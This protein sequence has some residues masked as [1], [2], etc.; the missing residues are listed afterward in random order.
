MFSAYYFLQVIFC[1]AILYGYYL[2]VLRNKPFHQYNRFYLL[3]VLVL[4][5]LIPLMRIEVA[6][7]AQATYREMPIKLFDV[8]TDNN[9]HWEEYVSNEATPFDWSAMPAYL[10]AGVCLLLVVMLLVSLVRI[11]QLLKKHSWKNIGDATLVMTS[12]KEAPFSFFRFIF[13]N[14]EIDIN[15]RV[16]K[17]IL[18]HELAHVRERHSLD[19]II[20]SLILSIGWIN[21][22]FWLIRRELSMVHE[23]I[24]D[25]QAVED[26][27]S[28]LAEMLLAASY[29]T[30][31]FGI[32]NSF[33][34]SPVKRRLSML[35]AMNITRFAYARRWLILPLLLITII[36]FAFRKEALTVKVADRINNATPGQ[37]PVKPAFPKMERTVAPLFGQE[38]T[39]P[40]DLERVYTVVIDPGHGGIDKGAIAADG[41][42]EAS[43][44]LEISKQIQELNTNKNLD[45]VL[46]REDDTYMHPKDKAEFTQKRKADLF[47][48]VHVNTAMENESGAKNGIEIFLPGSDSVKAYK[49]SYMFA[50]AIGTFLQQVNPAITLKTRKSGIW[51]LQHS[52]CP[53]ALIECGYISDEKDLQNLKAKEYQ[54]KLARKILEAALQYLSSREKGC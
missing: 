7:E 24:A 23:F 41:T 37:L 10:Y 47:I 51:V 9:S 29:P 19:K 31:A 34:H 42:T 16:G 52:N 54:Q 33:F 17:Q 5:W 28:E 50:N 48:S 30:T 18:R 8:V 14:S 1:S 44:A 43:L 46:V 26:N 45:I 13:W 53:A 15:S 40:H 22:V 20:N 27:A 12:V 39:G 4:S 3:S 35:S 32:T 25:K 11:Y 38:A 21:P 2:V 6:P 49:H 36:L